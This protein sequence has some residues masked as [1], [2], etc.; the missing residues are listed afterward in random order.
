MRE[1]HISSQLPPWPQSPP[2]T[3]TYTQNQTIIGYTLNSMHNAG[4]S[5]NWKV[6]KH[7]VDQK[8]I[9]FSWEEIF[10]ICQK[11]LK[12]KKLFYNPNC[13]TGPHYME[14]SE[15]THEVNEKFWIAT[16]DETIGLKAKLWDLM[17]W[18]PLENSPD[19]QSSFSLKHFGKD[20]NTGL[21]MWN[22]FL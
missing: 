7:T 13:S 8:S 19:I 20:Y 3:P 18:N 9:F 5:Q 11:T 15:Y 14:F 22:I 17:I 4:L 10:K 16:Q 21:N 6:K 12:I 2:H 1:N